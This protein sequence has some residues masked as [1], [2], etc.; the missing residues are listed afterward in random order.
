MSRVSSKKP[1]ATT[2]STIVVGL[3]LGFIVFATVIGVVAFNAMPSSDRQE[4]L[5]AFQPGVPERHLIPN[6]YKG[7]ITVEHHAVGESALP[8]EDGVNIFRYPDSGVLR[9]ST[10]WKP[11][12]KKKTVFSVTDEGPV[13]FATSGRNRQIWGNQNITVRNVSDGPI[14]ARRCRFFVGTHNEYR[15]SQSQFDP[16]VFDLE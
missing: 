9:T 1:P 15:K 8:M 7:W 4:F 16:H 6:G 13:E 2:N 5:G 10:G 12:I 11:G 3:L 14:V